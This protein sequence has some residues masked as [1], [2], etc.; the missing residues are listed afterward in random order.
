MKNHSRFSISLL[1]ILVL[2]F[3]SCASKKDVVYLQDVG[4]YETIVN[5]NENTTKL[6]IDDLVSI[7]VS[8]L[9]AEAS[10]PFNLFRSAAGGGLPSEQ[11]DYIVDKEG[12]I[13][14]P[15]IGKLKIN[16]LSPNELRSLLREKMAPYL[17]DPIINIRLKNFSVTILGAVNRPGTYLINGEQVTILEA[18]GLA[19]DLSIKGLRT[20]ILVISDFNGTKVYNRLDLTDKNFM[21]SPGYYLTQN[22]VVYVEPNKS[23]IYESSQDNRLGITISVVSLLITTGV[24]FITR[25]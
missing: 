16:G 9:D 20:N 22:D 5:N 13:D 6:K 21:K 7:F 24:L 18:L 8:T 10:I 11:V 19:G 25:N 12:E 3:S 17:K 15:V 4:D 23:G 14:F 2:I 1:F